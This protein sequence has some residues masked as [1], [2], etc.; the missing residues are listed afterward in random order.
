MADLCEFFFEPVSIELEAMLRQ[1]RREDAVRFAKDNLRRGY[2]SPQFLSLVADLLE[3]KTYRRRELRHWIEI[4]TDFD[5]LREQGNTREAALLELVRRYGYGE[6]TIR[7]AVRLYHSGIRA[8]Q[9][10]Q[11]E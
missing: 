11:E 6:T 7:N 3:G 8:S 1:G 2:S 4:G 5:E 10:S 9:A